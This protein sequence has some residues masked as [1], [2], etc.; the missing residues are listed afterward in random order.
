MPYSGPRRNLV[1]PSRP[2]DDVD[3]ELGGSR[4]D[5]IVGK[6]G[7]LVG[8]RSRALLKSKQAYRER[9]RKRSHRSEPEM[10]SSY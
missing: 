5:F 1:R 6:I 8:N 3:S 9:S 10:L 2:H 7:A 4:I